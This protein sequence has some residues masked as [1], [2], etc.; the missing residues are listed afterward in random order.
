MQNE[1]LSQTITSALDFLKKLNSETV[2]KVCFIKKDGT[3]REMVCTINFK[4][5]PKRLQ[6]KGNLD[7]ARIVKEITDG[8]VRV[9]DI[10]KQEWRIV[11]TKTTKWLEVEGLPRFNVK[12]G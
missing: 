7:L 6:P 9:F 12:L 4:L 8:H 1:E 3:E 11:N 5:I 2:V 10:N